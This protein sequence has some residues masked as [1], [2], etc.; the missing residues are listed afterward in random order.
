MQQC[1]QRGSALKRLINVRVP[2]GRSGCVR[3]A[4][5]NLLV[6]CVELRRLLHHQCVLF[7]SKPHHGPCPVHFLFSHTKLQNTAPGC[8]CE[9]VLSASPHLACRHVWHTVAMVR[10][11]E[12]IIAVS[13]QIQVRTAEG[14]EIAVP[15]H[16]DPNL[17]E[18]RNEIEL[19]KL[20]NIYLS[21][22]IAAQIV[23]ETAERHSSQE[24]MGNHVAGHG[25]HTVP[26]HSRISPYTLSLELGNRMD[27]E[28]DRV[29]RR[30]DDLIVDSV[31]V[32][33]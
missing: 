4:L 28:I 5:C 24:L 12:G 20:P 30:V 29:C 8:Y 33:N 9:L 13:T 11:P 15:T 3:L 2:D 10:S 18:V 6:G 27:A 23:A 31:D 21:A 16:Q 19:G 25:M 26:F 14:H 22:S 7:C 32:P 1:K 17:D